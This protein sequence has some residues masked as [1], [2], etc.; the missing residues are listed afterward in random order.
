MKSLYVRIR[1]KDVTSRFRCRRHLWGRESKGKSFLLCVESSTYKSCSRCVTSFA[2][3]S[4]VT[5]LTIHL[6]QVGVS[7]REQLSPLKIFV[8][9]K[10]EIN[11]TFGEISNYVTDGGEF[12]SSL[13]LDKMPVIDNADREVVLAFPDKVRGIREVLAR[14]HMKCVFFGR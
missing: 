1:R 3:A 6:P 5:I 7:N 13:E 11:L 9:A 12:L 8:L 2:K 10:K 14:D 4:P